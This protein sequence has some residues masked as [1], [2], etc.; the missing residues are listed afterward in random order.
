MRPAM[1]RL[2]ARI[3]ASSSDRRLE[4]RFGSRVGQRA[5]FGGMVR[6]F[7]PE[8]ADGF[9]GELEY[10]LARPATGAPPVRWTIEVTGGRARARPGTAAQPKLTVSMQLADFLRVATGAADP[11]ALVLSGRASVRG[12]FGLAARLPEMFGARAA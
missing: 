9:A 8:A 3:V 5:L 10:E 4:R 2:L 1:L 12:D 6:S 7:V 11:I